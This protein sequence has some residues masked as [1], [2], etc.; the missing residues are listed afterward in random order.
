MDTSDYGLGQVLSR[1][2][3]GEKWF[4]SFHARKLSDNRKY[5]TRDKEMQST[6][7]DALSLRHPYL[8]GFPH[9]VIVKSDSKTSHFM[10]PP[11][12]LHPL[13]QAIG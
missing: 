5:Y 6:I 4:M 11:S 1:I 9:K 3:N 7:D 2:V 13:V 10:T 8:M 12:H